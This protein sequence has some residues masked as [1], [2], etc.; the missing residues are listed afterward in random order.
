MCQSVQK[1]TLTNCNTVVLADTGAQLTVGTACNVMDS[2]WHLHQL[3]T[4]VSTY[5]NEILALLVVKRK[6]LLNFLCSV[7]YQTHIVLEIINGMA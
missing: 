6:D 1:R 3:N 4:A 5:T 7:N 2:S